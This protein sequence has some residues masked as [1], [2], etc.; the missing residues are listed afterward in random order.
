MLLTFSD[1]FPVSSSHSVFKSVL[2]TFKT[3]ESLEPLPLYRNIREALVERAKTPPDDDVS[4]VLFK[5]SA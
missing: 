1:G 5:F 4:I 3:A 2:S